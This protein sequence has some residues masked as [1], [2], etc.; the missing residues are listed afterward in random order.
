[1]LGESEGKGD[2]MD[3]EQEEHTS[4]DNLLNQSTETQPE[5]IQ[6]IDQPTQESENEMEEEGGEDIDVPQGEE[7]IL[8]DKVLKDHRSLLDKLEIEIS[9]SKSG[10]GHAEN[11]DEDHT[12]IDDNPIPMRMDQHTSPTPRVT[13]PKLH[14]E[15]RQDPVRRRKEH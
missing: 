11:S 12:D 7:D 2:K 1:M 8:C 4:D 15:V 10:T 14:H 9:S 5:P 3:I 13:Q 6:N